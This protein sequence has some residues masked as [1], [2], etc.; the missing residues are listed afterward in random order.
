[1]HLGVGGTSQCWVSVA[2]RGGVG[3]HGSPSAR[4][5]KTADWTQRLLQKGAAWPRVKK[6]CWRKE[7]V[8]LA[9]LQPGSGLPGPP[10]GEASI[11]KQLAEQ[12]CSLQSPG[13]NITEMEE[14]LR[15]E[16]E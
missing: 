15:A 13:S 6:P 12:E 1:M 11:T 10:T 5:V 16:R 9:L 4:A 7:H 14:G 2:V 3:S 8:A